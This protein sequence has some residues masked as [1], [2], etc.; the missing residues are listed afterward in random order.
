MQRTLRFRT[1]SHDEDIKEAGLVLD[2][3]EI[4]KRGTITPDEGVIAKWYGIYNMRQP[5]NYMARVVITGGVITSSQARMLSRVAENYA[6]GRIAITTRQDIQFHWLK[7]PRLPDFMRDVHETGLSTFHGCGDVNRNVV[8][9]IW[10]ESCRYKAFNVLEDAYSIAHAFIGD[11]SLDNLPRKFKISL[12]GCVGGCA[13][14]LLNDIGLVAVKDKKLGEGYRVF[15]GGGHGWKP[16]LGQQAFGFVPRNIIV[17]V[18]LAIGRLFRDH[19]NRFDRSRARLK[20][21]VE[22]LGVDNCAEII[23]KDLETLGLSKLIIRNYADMDIYQTIPKRPLSKTGVVSD[24]KGFAV[25]RCRIDKGEMRFDQLRKFAQLA[26]SY[27]DKKIRFTNRQNLEIHG[28]S[29]DDLPIVEESFC[30]MG[31]SHDGLEGLQ[32]MVS[33]VGT[34]YCPLATANTHELFSMLKPI[35]DKF[36]YSAIRDYCLVNIAGCPNGCSPYRFADIGFRGMRISEEFGSV[37]GFELTIGGSK[38]TLG[39]KI[40]DFRVEDCPKVLETILDCFANRRKPDET[41]AEHVRREGLEVYKKTIE[42]LGISHKKTPPITA[43]S[44]EHGIGITPLDYATYEREIPCSNACPA[45]TRVPHYIESIANG[46]LDTAY[47]INQEDN[48]FPGVLGRIC[49]RPCEKSCRHLWTGT[50]GSVAICHLKRFC[51]DN[52]KNIRIL[53]P[54]FPQTGKKVAIIGAGPSGLTAARELKRYGHEVVI[55]EKERVAGGMMALAIPPFRLPRDTLRKEIQAI[56][57]SGVLLKTQCEITPRDVLQ[58]LNEYQAVVIA[59]GAIEP[60]PLK[61]TN[62]DDGMSITGVDFLRKFNLQEV[63]SLKPPILVIGGG[64]TAVDCAR[65]ARRVLGKD[66]GEIRLVYRRTEADMSASFAEI[67]EMKR[68]G[69]EIDTLLSPVEAVV[70]GGILKAVKFQKNQ[71]SGFDQRA[72]KHAIEPLSGKFVTL[73]ASTLIVAIGQRKTKRMLPDGIEA[74][75][76]ATTY[77]GLFVAGDFS[78]GSLDVIHAVSDGKKVADQVDEYLMGK[79]RRRFVIN[80]V[81]HKTGWTGRVRDHD[82]ITPPKM[83]VATNETGSIHD[84]VELG[85]K[86]EDAHLNALRCYLCQY[87]YEIVQDLCIHC[88][89]CIKVAPR[90]CIKKVTRVFQNQTGSIVDYVETDLPKDATYIFIDSNMCI[91]CGACYRICPTGAITCKKLE[92]MFVN[93]R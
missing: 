50:D 83:P 7:C 61:I 4:A 58:L 71:L 2:F 63:S 37:E 8:T 23:L 42:S 1:K 6:Q 35:V 78:Y 38:E 10:A 14:P 24:D 69:I 28:V 29:I 64:Y 85:F 66:G 39:Q 74:R 26:E 72:R 67:Q 11:R 19:G 27:G 79:S 21:V 53:P 30:E 13:I 92:S 12:S 33:C 68:E 18:S 75:G 40:G 77:P 15:I 56:L 87:R 76:L 82:L 44:V 32:D 34:T 93:S 49:S 89:W 3:D 20:F 25:A 45:K 52:S 73:D 86:D 41:L 70:E 43:L 60:I 65:A 47:L 57:D 31:F 36:K 22:Q 90:D 84:E 9:C 51:A 5:G 81:D 88:D 62:L 59:A 91:R 55:F 48:V 46:D 17:P 16:Y 54:W 80:I